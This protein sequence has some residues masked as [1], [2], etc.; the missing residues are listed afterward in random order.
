MFVHPWQVADLRTAASSVWV[1]SQ[2]TAGERG[3]TNP[4]FSGALGVWDG[5]ILHEHPFVP[6]ATAAQA[7]SVGGTAANAQAFRSILVGQSAACLANASPDGSGVASTFMREESFDYQNKA[8]FA[9]GFIGGIALPTFNNLPY[10]A[11]LV[12][13]GATLL[14]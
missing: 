14:S 2:Q 9:V 8:G 5:V 11:V 4:L 13:T 12:D 7:F 6:T 10:G 3:S 1:A